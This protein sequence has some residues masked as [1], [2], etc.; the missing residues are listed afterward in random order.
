MKKFKE[1]CSVNGRW[2]G[3]VGESKGWFWSAIDSWGP[4]DADS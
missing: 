4:L 2:A 1:H 3:F